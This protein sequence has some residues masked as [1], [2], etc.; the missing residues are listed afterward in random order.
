MLQ[1]YVRQLGLAKIGACPVKQGR[2]PFDGKHLFGQRAENGSLIAAT[3]TDFERLAERF[4]TVEQQLDHAG[5][6]ERLRNRLA[7]NQRQG[8]VL[9]GPVRQ[10]LADEDVP[11][12]GSHGGEDA[13]VADA[14]FAQALDHPGAGT[15]RCHAEA[16]RR[17]SHA[18]THFI[19]AGR[20]RTPFME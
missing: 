13:L 10:R 15:L 4:A 14:L 11:R 7:E 17:Q 19:N 12:Y 8:R 6:N 16:A 9:V 1:T 20:L 3:G 5:D 18:R 2:Q